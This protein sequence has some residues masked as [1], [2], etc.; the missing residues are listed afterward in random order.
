MVLDSD[1]LIRYLVR[2]DLDK[3]NR[4][5]KFLSSGKKIIITDATCAEVYWTLLRFYK[6]DRADIISAL[7]SVLN[8]QSIK[9]NQALL[10]ACFNTLKNSNISFMDSYEAAYACLYSDCEVMSFNRGFDKIKKVKRVEP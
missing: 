2:D 6:K 3:A 7:E 10:F 5:K 8:H 9:C 4:F 1:V